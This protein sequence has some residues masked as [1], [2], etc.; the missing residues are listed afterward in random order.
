[1]DSP[2]VL[3][4]AASRHS[5]YNDLALPQREMSAVEQ[6]SGH[7]SAKQALVSRQYLEQAQRGDTRWHK[8]SN[9]LCAKGGYG[10]S[11]NAILGDTGGSYAI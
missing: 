3:A 4:A 7:E 9:S 10:G 11:A 2:F 6:S 5:T 8:R 1:V